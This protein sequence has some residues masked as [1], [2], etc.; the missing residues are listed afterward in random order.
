MNTH[1]MIDFETLGQKQDCVVLSLGAV[2]FTRDGVLSEFY[3]AFDIDTQPGRTKQDDTLA[4]W[5][6]QSVDARAIFEECKN[7]IE[8]ISLPEKFNMF[9]GAQKQVK[10]WSNGADF[11]IP[12]LNHIY[13]SYGLEVPWKFFNHR[14]YRT[15]KSLFHVEAPF[16]F[17]GVKHNALADAKYQAKCLAHFFR[18]NPKADGGGAGIPIAGHMTTL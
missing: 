1:L 5:S 18:E 16:K 10:I 9:I 8:L 15:M 12:I 3:T 17:D 7:G 4:W 11:D 6:K 14:C 2:L 13:A